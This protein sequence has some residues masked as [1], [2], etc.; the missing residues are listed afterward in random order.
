MAAAVPVWKRVVI[1]CRSA[2]Q[3]SLLPQKRFICRDILFCLQTVDES[4]LG[5]SRSAMFRVSKIQSPSLRI[6]PMESIPQRSVVSQDSSLRAHMC[7]KVVD[8]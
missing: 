2:D 7:Q 6:S 5:V 8:P 4:L 3:S 1:P